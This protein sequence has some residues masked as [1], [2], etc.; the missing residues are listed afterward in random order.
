M[1]KDKVLL[2]NSFEDYNSSLNIINLEENKE[3]ISNELKETIKYIL[4]LSLA[5]CI[6]IGSS[7]ILRKILKE[8]FNVNL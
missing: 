4:V 8:L 5:E 3:L 1:F 6:F 7:M 2:N